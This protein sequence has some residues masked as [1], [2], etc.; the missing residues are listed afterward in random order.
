MT[1]A[2]TVVDAEQRSPEWFSARL[3]R[4]T[5]SKAKCVMMGATTAGRNDYI[6]QLALERLTGIPEEPGFVNN[7]MLRGIEKEPF[8]LM[9]AESTGPMIRTTGF[10][11]HDELMIGASLDGDS[12]EFSMVWEFK[13]PKSTTHLKYLRSG[14]ETLIEDYLFQL[15]HNTYVT[16]AKSATAGSF[17]DR[18][19]TGLDWVQCEVRADKL[20]IF[21]Y[22]RA[23]HKFL[24]EVQVLELEL[25]E[26]LDKT[27]GK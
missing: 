13:C 14:G 15:T 19:P 18:M 11:R 22:E 24:A 25:R 4:V 10:I 20:P 1:R 16:G 26:M 17:D 2:F 6:M 23:L 7:E 27:Q 8:A 5:G 21:E 9:R 3:G 12:E